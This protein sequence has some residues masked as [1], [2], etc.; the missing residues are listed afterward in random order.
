VWYF[1][2]LLGSDTLVFLMYS[3]EVSVDKL[4]RVAYRK[5]S[6]KAMRLKV[7]KPVCGLMIYEIAEFY[8][9]SRELI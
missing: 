9:F 4:R 8:V 3:D 5:C 1:N 7:I 2:K 6:T